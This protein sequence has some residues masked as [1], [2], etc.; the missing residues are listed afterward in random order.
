MALRSGQNS[1]SSLPQT[2]ASAGNFRSSR[3]R[4]PVGYPFDPTKGVYARLSARHIE[5]VFRDH[6]NLSD[7]DAPT[8]MRGMLKR[9]RLGQ[10]GRRVEAAAWA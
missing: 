7:A 1:Q 5:E 2:A 6:F 4:K 10:G 3:F 8:G 9:L